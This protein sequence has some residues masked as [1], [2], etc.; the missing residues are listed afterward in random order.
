[1]PI[2]TEDQKPPKG[3]RVKWEVQ[4][5]GHCVWTVEVEA[6]SAEEALEIACKKVE[7][8]ADLEAD[9]NPEPE[10]S[11]AEIVGWEPIEETQPVGHDGEP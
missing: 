2:Y 6:A 4:I 3:Q 8:N 11:D 1:M 10:F 7:D 9:D 5:P